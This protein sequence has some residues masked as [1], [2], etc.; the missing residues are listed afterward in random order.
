[1][2]STSTLIMSEI[3]NPVKKLPIHSQWLKVSHTKPY[4]MIDF[5]KLNQFKH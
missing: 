4:N 1:M 5:S 3:T 2:A